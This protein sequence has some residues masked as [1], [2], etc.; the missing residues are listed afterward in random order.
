[1]TRMIRFMQLSPAVGLLG[2]SHPGQ[3]VPNSPAVPATYTGTAAKIGPAATTA[4]GEK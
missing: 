2:R 3:T 1:M 4:A